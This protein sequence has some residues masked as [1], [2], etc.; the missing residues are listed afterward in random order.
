MRGVDQ[1][2]GPVLAEWLVHSLRG[3]ST[4][5]LVMAGPGR[6]G[7]GGALRERVDAAAQQHGWLRVEVGVDAG[8][9][10]TS[11]TSASVDAGFARGSLEALVVVTVLGDGAIA[12]VVAGACEGLRAGG[13]VIEL[14]H[15]PVLRPWQMLR[16]LRRTRVMRSAAELRARA[17]LG[18]GVYAVEQWAPIDL[19]RVLVT[20]GRWRAIPGP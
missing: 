9:A 13:L 4:G 6:G 11:T 14:G 3:R 17:W 15:P 16:W 19:P 8:L 10:A 12:A 1:L 20:C 2:S 5:L 18:L 7:T